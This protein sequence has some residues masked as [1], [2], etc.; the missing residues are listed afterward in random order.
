MI[1][2]TYLLVFFLFLVVRHD[3]IAQGTVKLEESTG[4]EISL[5]LNSSQEPCISPKQYAEIEKRCA[6]N[7]QKLG[8]SNAKFKT[9]LLT[10]LA[11]PLK[12]KDGITD[13]SYY[14]ISAHVDQDPAVG[15]FKDYNCGNNSY[16]GHHGTDIAIFPFPF[17]K[18]DNDI[19]EV[20][21]AAPGMIVDK[22]DGNFDKNCGANNLQA[23]YIVVQHADGSRVLYFH[24]KKN[25]LTSKVIGQSV[26]EGEYLGVVG[27]SGNSTG[28][29]LHFEV[30]VNGDYVNPASYIGG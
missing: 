15:T 16:D 13:C 14:A 10:S 5:N 22:S 19:V 21:A 3:S 6:L 2:I 1:K 20:I 28:P 30:R 18:L 7:L 11:W 4:G 9:Q 27:S 24:M 23:N 8:I 17:Y 26:L 29:H 25:S 12:L